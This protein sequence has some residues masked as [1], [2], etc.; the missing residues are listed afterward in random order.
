MTSEHYPEGADPDTLLTQKEVYYDK[1]KLASLAQ[2]TSHSYTNYKLLDFFDCRMFPEDG[3]NDDFYLCKAYQPD[4]DKVKD[5][6][7]RFGGNEVAWA[8]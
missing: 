8:Y 5:G 6:Y 4:H 1:L 7:P 2:T 3:T